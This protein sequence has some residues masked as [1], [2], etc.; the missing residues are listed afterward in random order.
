M[1]DPPPAPSGA[2]LDLINSDP[3]AQSS[4]YRL[5]KP[6]CAA[7]HRKIDLIGKGLSAYNV[8]GERDPNVTVDATQG[9]LDGYPD[10]DFSGPAALAREARETGRLP[11]CLAR[12][13]LT[14]LYGRGLTETDDPALATV[15]RDFK[16]S[17]FR[18]KEALAKYF[19]S[20]GF[21]YRKVDAQ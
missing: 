9:T 4:E 3:E 11:E 21:L 1:C 2:I 18:F 19:T 10:S 12:H 6:V 8:Y 5:S 17:D 14:W 20:E 16:N 7:C 13:A 15:L